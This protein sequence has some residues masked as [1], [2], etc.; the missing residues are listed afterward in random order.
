MTHFTDRVDV[1]LLNAIDH[2]DR[3]VLKTHC[4]SSRILTL[5]QL[6]ALPVV[7]TIRDPRDAVV[8]L[9]QRFG[10][11]FPTALGRVQQSAAIMVDVYGKLGPLLLK[12]EGAFIGKSGIAA[13]ARHLCLTPTVHAVTQLAEGL[14]SENICLHLESLLAS[15]QL[16]GEKPD[17]E[18]EAATQWHPH[19]IGDR[20]IG[21]Y[22]DVLA[23]A[24]IANMNDR[25]STFLALFGYDDQ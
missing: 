14:S 23:P 4:P 21:K 1:T 7:M 2:G 25:M 20:R 24:Q 15:G 12:Y 6:H 3:F 9:M 16:R 13:I 10:Q 5:C 18:W 11:D 19:H 8:S 17:E 22:R